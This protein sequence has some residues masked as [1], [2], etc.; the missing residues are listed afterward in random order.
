[1]QSQA[2]K[3]LK[4]KLIVAP[5]RNWLQLILPSKRPRVESGE[6]DKHNSEQQWETSL[7]RTAPPRQP[8]VE[9]ESIGRERSR[10]TVPHLP[11]HSNELWWPAVVLFLGSWTP[12]C[13]YVSPREPHQPA[14]AAVQRQ[15]CCA[16]GHL[17]SNRL[18]LLSLWSPSL[19]TYGF[20]PPRPDSPEGFLVLGLFN[21][22]SI[23]SSA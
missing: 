5:S 15:W 14:G 22:P 10:K 8:W 17:P 2:I 11:K 21:F 1:M 16:M 6:M 7:S 12:S 19:P 3:C 18:H 4:S 9:G 13:V 20:P 23:S